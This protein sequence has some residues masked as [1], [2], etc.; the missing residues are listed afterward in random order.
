VPR[1]P[2]LHRRDVAILEQLAERGA[3]TLRT[4]HDRHFA[5]AKRKTARNRIAPRSARRLPAPHR[6][7]GT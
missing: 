2:H 6:R 5:E 4:L 3:D 1:R 7:D